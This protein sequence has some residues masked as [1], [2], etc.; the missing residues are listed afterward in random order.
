M[1][2]RAIMDNSTVTARAQKIRE[3]MMIEQISGISVSDKENFLSQC[4]NYQQ[5]SV[6]YTTSLTP[7]LNHSQ[8]DEYVNW[9]RWDDDGWTDWFKFNRIARK[10]MPEQ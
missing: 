4:R 9:A 2:K 1:D 5:D 8:E 6:Q 10:N 3:R 7:Q